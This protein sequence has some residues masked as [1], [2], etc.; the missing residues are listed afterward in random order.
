MRVKYKNQDNEIFVQEFDF[1]ELG[2]TIEFDRE[3]YKFPSVFTCYEYDPNKDDYDTVYILSKMN[4]V[5][6]DC[7]MEKLLA[8]GYIDFSALP[9][10]SYLDEIEDEYCENED[11]QLV[12]KTI[13]SYTISDLDSTY[14]WSKDED[15]EDDNNLIAENKEK[16]TEEN[17]EAKDNS[18]EDSEPLNS[19][20]KFLK[21]MG[22]S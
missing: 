9:A 18:T 5:E 1:V 8:S 16:N 20:D 11:Y 14:D 3:E 2:T 6:A 19:F 10:L 4:P 12:M 13:E 15:N 17:T 22:I 21:I 7:Y